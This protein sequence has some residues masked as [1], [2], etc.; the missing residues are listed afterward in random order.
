MN[1]DY[2]DKV[3]TLQA[4]LIAFMDEHIYPNEKRFYDEIAANRAAGNE[5]GRAHV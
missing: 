3:K 1:F 2:S 5:I 4:R